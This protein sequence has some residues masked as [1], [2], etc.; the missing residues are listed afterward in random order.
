MLVRVFSNAI[1]GAITF[2]IIKMHPPQWLNALA[3][4][5]RKRT[6]HTAREL[7]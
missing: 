3:E 7:S 5:P 6:I 1:L 2:Q 4:P